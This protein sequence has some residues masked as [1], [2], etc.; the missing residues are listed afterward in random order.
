MPSLFKGQAGQYRPYL[1]KQIILSNLFKETGTLICGAWW[2][3]SLISALQKQRQIDLYEL[4]VSLL[5]KERPYLKQ[6]NHK[7]KEKKNLKLLLDS[8]SNLAF[9]R[10]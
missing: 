3:I 10:S 2:H 7:R 1:T 4:Q 5:Y 8:K 9:K 6:T